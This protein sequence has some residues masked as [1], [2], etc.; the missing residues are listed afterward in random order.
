MVVMGGM[1]PV[2]E[3]ANFTYIFAGLHGES[4]I[5]ATVL[6]QAESMNETGAGLNV[7]PV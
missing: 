3:I 4:S 7:G 5:C 6:A 1:S 2:S